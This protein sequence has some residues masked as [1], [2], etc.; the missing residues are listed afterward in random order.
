ME[1]ER[2]RVA[3]S[4]RCVECDK[5]FEID[6]PVE[7]VF[8]GHCGHRQRISPALLRE[9][10]DFR[11]QVDAHTYAAADDLGSA[12]AFER[13]AYQVKTGMR[14]GQVLLAIGLTV[15][16]PMGLILLGVALIEGG[17]IPAGNDAV[18]G[19]LGM[20][21]SL[22]GFVA[23]MVVYFSRGGKKQSAAIALST[24]VRCPEC[25]ATNSFAGSND[26]ATCTHCGAGL[27]PETATHSSVIES[28][29]QQR[30]QAHMM[31]IRAERE[32]YAVY[33]GVGVKPLTM[34][35]IIG[36]PFV[37]MTGGASIGWTVE[38]LTGEEPFHRPYLS[39]GP[40]LLGCF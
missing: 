9:M 23:Y 16:I 30:R 22:I 17:V 39:C 5:S 8:C 40:S 34:V 20:G 32:G 38:M 2:N 13:T 21:G 37:L 11:V 18:I 25:G 4:V 27:I 6:G 15:G 31:K 29:V 36:G 10:R 35:W 26:T 3:R 28:A 7:T 14:P 1:K 33:A 19:A 12:A 24:Q